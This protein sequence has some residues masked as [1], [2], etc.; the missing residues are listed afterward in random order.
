MRTWVYILEC[1]DNRYYVGS[2]RGDDIDV[3][4]SEHNAGTYRDAWTF[5]RRPVKLAWAD[6][7]PSAVQA[8][9]VERQLKG[10]SRAKKEAVIRGELRRLAKRGPAD[11]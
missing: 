4:V 1:V 11:K 10:W 9:A 3:R 7:Y 6:S 2:Y 5:S 8:I